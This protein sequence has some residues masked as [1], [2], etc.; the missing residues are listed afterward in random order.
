MSASCTPL[1]SSKGRSGCAYASLRDR[2]SA[3]LDS[4]STARSGARAHQ[5]RSFGA[6]A[7]KPIQ[8]EGKTMNERVNEYEVPVDPQ[9]ELECDSCQ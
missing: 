5:S 8:T 7:R 6:E 4:R 1:H 3:A 2:A 9:A